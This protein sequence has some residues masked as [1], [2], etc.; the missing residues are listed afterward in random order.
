MFVR[1]LTVDVNIISYAE[2]KLK[3]NKVVDTMLCTSV[4]Q[5]GKVK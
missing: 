1:L 2:C 5:V 4:P 3:N